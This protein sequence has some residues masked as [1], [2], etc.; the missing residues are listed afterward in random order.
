MINVNRVI[1]ITTTSSSI[2]DFSKEI[3]DLWGSTRPKD[4]IAK[5][6]DVIF[7]IPK[8]ASKEDI[9]KRYNLFCK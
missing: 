3:E 8:D 9:I 2:E 5:F 7:E 4:Y 6:N 1:L